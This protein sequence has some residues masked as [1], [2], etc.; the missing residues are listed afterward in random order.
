MG[1][2]ILIGYVQA[3][4]EMSA[5]EYTYRER[6]E[7]NPQHHTPRD[8]HRNRARRVLWAKCTT[9]TMDELKK[10]KQKGE[11]NQGQGGTLR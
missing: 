6:K 4:A 2:V 11:D 7:T 3:E 9:I 10:K 8:N 1:L 5:K